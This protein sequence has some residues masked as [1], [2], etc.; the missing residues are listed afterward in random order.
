MQTILTIG[1]LPHW[2][3]NNSE[4]LEE[5]NCNHSHAHTPCDT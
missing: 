5:R 2:I 1:H 3:E 4:I